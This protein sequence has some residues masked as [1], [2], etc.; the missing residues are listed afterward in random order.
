MVPARASLAA[1]KEGGLV[2]RRGTP[3]AGH[4]HRYRQIASALTRHGLGYLVGLLGLERWIPFHKG[5]LGHPR[6]ETPYSQAEHLRM[7]LEDLGTTFIKVGQIVSTRPD[8][9]PP[10][11][12][13]ELAKLQDAA[14]PVSGEAIQQVIQG[15]LG[16]PVDT[17]F[18]SFDPTPVAA[19][20]IGQAHAAT[21]ADGTEVV[22]KVRRP[23]V[24]GQVEEDLQILLNLATAAAHRWEVA[25]DY[26]VA[27]IA[28]EFS[29]T[30]RAEMDY[31]REGRNAERIASNFAGDETI[32]VP[33]IF[34]DLTT[35][36]VLTL[37]RIHGMKLT[38]ATV[39]EGADSQRRAMAEKAAAFLLKMVFED[40]FFHADP[41][42][43]NLF[44]EP[45]GRIGL[46]DFG[47]VGSVDDKTQEQLVLLL[48]AITSQDAD[49]LVDAFLDLGVAR[50]R[51]ER[52]LLRQDLE[53]LLSRY[54]GL[55][56]G[57]IALGELIPDALAVVRRHHLQLPANL[58]LLL[59]TVVM[60]EG[61]VTQIDPT[62]NLTSFLAPYAKSL[63]LRRFAPGLWLSRFGHAG[64]DAARLGVEMPLRVRRL[65]AEVERGG[66]EVAMR[67]TGFEPILGRLERLVN[68]LVLGIL[69]AAFVVGLAVVML[70][71]HPAG[72]E[73]L[74]GGFFFF[75][76]VAAGVFGG[77]LTWT[78]VRSRHH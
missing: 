6:R 1:P 70:V 34:W 31:I 66:L 3:K 47:M 40:G 64:L 44:L 30:L 59:K 58:A 26:D 49:Q 77:Y 9:L 41:H 61:L 52:S 68:R 27:G 2:S 18:A 76:F 62:F 7:V 37:E 60:E 73:R 13:Q 69:A 4:A 71:Y 46:I 23:G 28:Q 14:P 56:L 39:Q 51:V 12:Q 20:S 75:G 78:I 19:A 74:M 72:W 33:R 8:L 65:L 29:Q 35:Q 16:A 5:L 22:I 38:E 57:E 67:P 24:V 36:R 45:D 25:D 50:R 43:G 10:E 55:P 21:L 15:E 17:L 54:Y 63:M 53:H 32:H 48:L 11:Y 42:P